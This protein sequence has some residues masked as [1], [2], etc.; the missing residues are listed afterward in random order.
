[1]QRNLGVF[2]SITPAG[3]SHTYSWASLNVWSR[4]TYMVIDAANPGRSPVR[5][6]LMPWNK[7]PDGRELEAE[8]LRDPPRQP[9]L[10]GH[11]LRHS[12]RLESGLFHTRAAPMGFRTSSS[13][14][15]SRKLEVV[16][17]PVPVQTSAMQSTSS[18][19]AEAVSLTA[20]S[21]PCALVT[22]DKPSFNASRPAKPACSPPCQMG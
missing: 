21:V 15:P 9:Y 22:A 18:A 8:D 4:S 7:R 3:E 17:L 20:P 13:L 11:T 2:L 6:A 10:F 5:H 1:M 12:L 14:E 19:I 16:E